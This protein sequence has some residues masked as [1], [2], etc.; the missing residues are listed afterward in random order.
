LRGGKGGD[1]GRGKV[2]GRWFSKGRE[3]RYW[4]NGRIALEK[5]FIYVLSSE[6]ELPLHGLPSFSGGDWKIAAAM[7]EVF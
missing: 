5:R 4:G 1:S 2:Y 6:K 7:R 3:V